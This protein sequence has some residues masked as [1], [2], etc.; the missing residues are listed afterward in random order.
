MKKHHSIARKLYDEYARYVKPKKTGNYFSQQL[1]KRLACTQS[2]L[3]LLLGLT[4]EMVSQSERAKKQLSYTKEYR[5]C[6]VTCLVGGG[7]AKE[8]DKYAAEP[9]AVE[10]A[11]ALLQ[12]FEVPTRELEMERE[13]LK[14]NI[15]LMEEV[16]KKR[17]EEAAQ[18]LEAYNNLATHD[19][20]KFDD[21]T[22]DDERWKRAVA[23]N[24]IRTRLKAITGRAKLEDEIRLDEWRVRLARIEKELS[25]RTP[26][27]KAHNER[28][29]YDAIKTVVDLHE[30]PAAVAD[31]AARVQPASAE[32]TTLKPE[33]NPF[34]ADEAVP[35]AADGNVYDASSS[36][37]GEK[38]N[39]GNST[40]FGSEK[41]ES[42]Q[43]W[44]REVWFERRL[45]VV[46]GR[47]A[48]HRFI[49]GAADADRRV[50]RRA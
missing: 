41:S 29:L 16:L 47:H 35:V 9:A 22:E 17:E 14:T 21:F 6:V 13:V 25:E 40:D 33:A 24:R 43:M 46:I 31:D 38:K 19:L 27:A 34:N 37:E 12:D 49:G 20:T 7:F 30:A 1:R 23:M 10:E 48:R 50:L 32:L 44:N 8:A 2:D 11:L 4:R 3:S 5:L 28:P 42:E 39:D 26:T 36:A 18:L 15:L 45:P